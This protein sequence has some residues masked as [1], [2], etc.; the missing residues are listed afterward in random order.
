M[1][2][3]ACGGVGGGAGA[4]AGGGA[5]AGAALLA[6]RLWASDSIPCLE[7]LRSLRYNLDALRPPLI[8][9]PQLLLSQ[10][11]GPLRF[12]PELL[13]LMLRRFDLFLCTPSARLQSSAFHLELPLLQRVDAC[14]AVSCFCRATVS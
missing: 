5:G 1:N 11:L 4:G 2:C 14:N 10:C 3:G 7:L 8:A 9:P 13:L 6:A 12:E